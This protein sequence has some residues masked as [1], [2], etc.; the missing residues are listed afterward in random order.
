MADAD[1]ESRWGILAIAGA[2]GLCCVSIGAIAG[3]AAA[4]G[5]AAAGVTAASG[6]VRTLGGLVVTVVATALPLLVLGLVL[7]RRSRRA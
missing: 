6:V 5:G 7:R 2:C 3:G 4:V 1:G